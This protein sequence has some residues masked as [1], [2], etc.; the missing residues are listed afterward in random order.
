M[1]ISS[2]LERVQSGPPMISAYMDRVSGAAMR[3]WELVDK[4]LPEMKS[5]IL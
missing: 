2:I 3:F 4:Y 1:L 5:K